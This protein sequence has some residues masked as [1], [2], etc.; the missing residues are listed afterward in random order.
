MH[1]VRDAEGGV[2][3]KRRVEH[4]SRKDINLKEMADFMDVRMGALPPRNVGLWFL[5]ALGLLPHFL[6]RRPYFLGPQ[7]KPVSS[8]APP[9]LLRS[10]EHLLLDNPSPPISVAALPGRPL[11]LGLCP[12]ALLAYSLIPVPR[13]QGKKM[14]AI[15]SDAASTG[16][17][18]HADKGHKNKRKRV[19]YTLELPWSA[20]K[21]IQ[22]FGRSHRSNQ[23]VPPTYDLLISK[24]GGER[25]FASCAARRLMS[26]G[27][28]TKGDRRAMGAGSDLKEFEI[29]EVCGKK[30]TR[31]PR[32][33]REIWAAK[34]GRGGARRG[35]D[36]GLR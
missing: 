12:P 21:A 19:H 27:A 8:A 2:A 3:Y 7:A 9:F 10:L 17:S 18:L 35:E 22:Q 1:I 32:P 11:P 36:G 23:V 24:C 31:K 30:V 26:L 34:G 20:D 15:I 33:F 13:L 6:P 29:D 28:L 14:V 25:R 16:I 5:P 4:V